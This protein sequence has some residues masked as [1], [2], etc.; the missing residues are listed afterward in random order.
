MIRPCSST[1]EQDRPKIKARSSNLRR[2]SLAGEP[3]F[4]TR[5][6]GSKQVDS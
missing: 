4:G 1:E 6:S 5:D 3:A 2:G